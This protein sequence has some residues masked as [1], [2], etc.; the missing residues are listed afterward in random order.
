[1]GLVLIVDDEP[2]VR[3]VIGDIVIRLGYRAIY[4]DSVKS[5]MRVIND[6]PIDVAFI[7]LDLK[8][9]YHGLHVLYR[10]DELNLKIP[11]VIIFT[12]YSNVENA[13]EAMDAGAIDFLSKPVGYHTIRMALNVAMEVSTLRQDNAKLLA[14]NQSLKNENTILKCQQ[15]DFNQEFNRPTLKLD[16]PIE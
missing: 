6:N 9:E 12:G 7:D 10:M 14:E 8:N 11:V 16:K 15:N 2:A 5:A 13:I 1:M 3:K 4:A